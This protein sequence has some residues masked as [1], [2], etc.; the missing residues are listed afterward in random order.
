MEAG[1]SSVEYRVDVPAR[2]RRRGRADLGARHGDR[3]RPS[4]RD[5]HVS[6]VSDG[7]LTLRVKAT[8]RGSTKVKV[9]YLGSSVL[10]ASAASG[11]YRVR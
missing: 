3:C 2:R 9:R 4:D 8:G 11:R 7:R 1:V 6:T 5:R 10:D